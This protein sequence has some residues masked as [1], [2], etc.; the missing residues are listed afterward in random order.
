MALYMTLDQLE[1]FLS[2]VEQGSFRAASER[3]NKAQSAISYAIH[4]LED[5]TGITLFDRSHYRPRLS[6][7]GEVF[8]HKAK[9]LLDQAHQ[10]KN[11][12]QTLAKGAEPYIRLAICPLCPTQPIIDF[13]KHFKQRFPDTRIHFN[14]LSLRGP[15]EAILTD[16]AHFGITELNVDQDNLTRKDYKKMEMIPVCAP[17]YISEK[18]KVSK[19]LLKKYT[20]IVVS[21][22]PT[23]KVPTT[24]AVLPGGEHWKVADFFTKRS[25]LL[26]GMG[27][28]YMP[29]H[30]I[31]TDL[32]KKKLKIIP[33]PKISTPLSII[34][35][36]TDWPGPASQYI[37]ENICP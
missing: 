13:L 30:F 36:N 25:L 12:A 19:E 15:I 8:L 6:P 20:Q 18:Q 32:K 27:W 26:A 21:D 10:L 7:E 31:E 17:N 11:L 2:I 23:T 28:G 33:Y 34:C 14:T 37:W 4:Q 35:K 22:N 24:V 29:D 5:E 9:Q 1:A 3:L 16:Q